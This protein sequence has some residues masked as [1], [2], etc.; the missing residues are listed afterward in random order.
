[1]S[2]L[3]AALT[4]L[5]AP[6]PAADCATLHQLRIYRVPAGN[7]EAFHARFRDHAA[8]IMERHDFTIRA[9]WEARD[10]DRLEFVYLL[11]WPDAATLKA[12]WD[13]FLNDPE[14]VRIKK[15]TAALHGSYVE[16][17]EDRTMCLVDYS[18]GLKAAPAG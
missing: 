13:A 16:G 17:I 3:A 10:G 8:R 1:M 9:M 4:A 12:R 18:P 15:E 5:A 7:R 14:W 2:I 6:A 11:E